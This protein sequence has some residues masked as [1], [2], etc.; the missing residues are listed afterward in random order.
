MILDYYIEDFIGVFE[1]EFDGTE[2]INLNL[3]IKFF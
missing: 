1:T 2:F 3:K